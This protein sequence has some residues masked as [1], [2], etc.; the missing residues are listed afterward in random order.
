MISR[1]VL[2]TLIFFSII[3]AGCSFQSKGQPTSTPSPLSATP[4]FPTETVTPALSKT[5]I[6]ATETSTATQPPPTNTFTN[7]STN[8]P[9]NTPTKTPTEVPPSLLVEQNAVCRT[10]SG[11]NFQIAGYLSEGDTTSINGVVEGDLLWWFIQ[12]DEGEKTCW[13]SDNVVTVSGSVA[14][15]PRMTPPPTPTSVAISVPQGEG[16]YYFLVAEDTGGPFGC[17]DSILYIYPGIERTGVLTVDITNALNALFSNKHQ[18]YNGLYNPM[19]ASSLRVTDVDAIPG[20]PEI[21]V[22]LAGDFA[23]PK[24][25]CDSFRMR[26]QVWET[27]EIQFPEVPHAVIRVHNALLGDLLVTGW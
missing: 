20:E 27:I 24:D 25:K 15:V 6:P 26:A 3:I 7:T 9:T 19:Y 4:I 18:Y 16:I 13:I 17:G 1:R 21:Q 8:T 5:P 10:G 14:S 22:W 12:I 2:R 11:T 23:R